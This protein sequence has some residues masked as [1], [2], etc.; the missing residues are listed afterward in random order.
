MQQRK[1]NNKPYKYAPQSDNAKVDTAQ[2]EQWISIGWYRERVNKSFDGNKKRPISHT[3]QFMLLL[4]HFLRNN[5][6]ID[7]STGDIEM[8]AFAIKSWHY[9]SMIFDLTNFVFLCSLKRLTGCDRKKN[10]KSR[11]MRNQHQ[12]ITDVNKEQLKEIN[13]NLKCLHQA[14]INRVL[15]VKI[16]A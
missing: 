16:S 4:R 6:A 14:R 3:L 15:V 12:N 11:S 1:N 10:G 9:P 8:F 7:I 5:L 2:Q 13:S